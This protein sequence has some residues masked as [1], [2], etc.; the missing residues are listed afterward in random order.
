[1]PTRAHRGDVSDS[2]EDEIVEIM[3]VKYQATLICERQQRAQVSDK[4]VLST[5]MSTD[6]SSVRLT[7]SS[8]SATVTAM[9]A[10]TKLQERAV[11]IKPESAMIS[12][13][14]THMVLTRWR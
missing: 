1:M 13:K 11:A 9:Q 14:E 6:A 8:I 10:G 3:K 4:T 7:V 12:Y 5:N 2:K